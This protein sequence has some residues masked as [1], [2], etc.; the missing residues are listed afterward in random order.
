M[1]RRTFLQSASGALAAV[2]APALVV[3]RR[4]AVPA[5]IADGARVNAQLTT[6]DRIGRTAGG[7]NR[8]AYSENDLAGR[9]FTLDLFRA[10][11]MAPRIDAAGNIVGRVEGRDARA[12]PLVIGSHVD[13]VPDGGNYDGTL[14]SFAAIE[15]ARTLRERGERLRHPLEVVVWANEEG[16]TIGSQA[17][18]GHLPASALDLTARSGVTIRE[19]MTRIGGDATKLAAGVRAPGSIAGYLELHIEQGAKLERAGIA[20]GVVQGIVGLRWT[21]VTVTGLANHAGAT[22]MDRRQDA[23][24]AAARFTVAVNDIARSESG[25]QV[26]TVGRMVPVPNTTNVIAGEVTCT[27]DLRDLDP[28]KLERLQARIESAGTEI[29]RASSTTFAYAPASASEPALADP[30]LMTI[31]DEAARGL[32]LSTRTMPSG[33]GHDAQELARIGPM[34]MIFVPSVGGISHS[35]RE[36]STPQACAQGVDVLLRAVIAADRALP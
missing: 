27:V 19:G 10:A 34:A 4:T 13:S 33:A 14:G 21:T 24:L 2:A 6:F 5:L 22:E 25:A 32:A 31:V 28:V 36:F 9:A 29:G 26:A 12:F 11:G 3:P 35:P 18:V 16:G 15:V 17:A 7:I 23:L 8:V 30:R 1:D 20:I